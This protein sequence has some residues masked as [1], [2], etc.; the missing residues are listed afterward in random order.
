LGRDIKE[1]NNFRQ[2]KVGVFIILTLSNV[3]ISAEQI[4]KPASFNTPR[5]L[6]ETTK[7]LQIEI[8]SQE[9]LELEFVFS[10]ICATEYPLNIFTPAV[11][12][13]SL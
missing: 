3:F 4:L 5:S 12:S 2:Q 9:Y 13:L 10:A 7:F 11:T 1:T 6:P 8:D